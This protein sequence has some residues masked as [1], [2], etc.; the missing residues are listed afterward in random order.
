MTNIKHNLKRF[1]SLFCLSKRSNSDTI[2]LT[3]HSVNPDHKFSV[4]PNEFERQ[5]KYLTENFNV[6]SLKD[7]SLDPKSKKQLVITFDDGYEDNYTFAYPI[8]KKHGITATIFLA[9]DFI[10]N[11][12]DITKDWVPYNGLKPLNTDQIKEMSNNGITF[13]SHSK[14]HRRLSGINNSELQKEIFDSKKEIENNLGL[15]AFSF[16][17]PF[18]QKKDFNDNCLHFLKE[19]G[20]TAACSNMWG[21]NKQNKVNQYGLKRIEINYLDSYKDFVNKINGKWDFISFFQK[22]KSFI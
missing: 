16:S 21:V 22:I 9:S 15:N 19:G 13:G 8:L 3:Y 1:L 14:T 6:I 20:Y 4:T 2:V 17:Y 12:L 18:G 7:I 11:N 5:V 10:F